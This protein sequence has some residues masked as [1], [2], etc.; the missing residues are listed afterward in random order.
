MLNIKTKSI[1]PQHSPEGGS[2]EK[3]RERKLV[4]R[5]KV[6]FKEE[7]LKSPLLCS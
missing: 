2:A 4:K 3:K 1:N 5:M 7:A 6:N